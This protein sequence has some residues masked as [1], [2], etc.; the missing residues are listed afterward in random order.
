MDMSLSER[1]RL[2][3]GAIIE[4]Y[5]TF[6]DTIGSRTLVK[7]YNF[8]FSSATIR[9]VMADLE[10]LGYIKKT[11]TS[12]GRVPTDL[13]YKFYLQELL[14]IRKLSKLEKEK[15]ELA[16]EKR[17]LELDAIFEKTSKLLSKM[18]S[19][20]AIVIEPKIEKELIKKIEI[21]Q[22][23]DYTIM[24]IAVLDD[25]SVKTRKIHLDSPITDEETEYI[26]QEIKKELKNSEMTLNQFYEKIKEML[27]NKIFENF[28]EKDD[29]DDGLFIR[30]ESNILK[31]LNNNN[32]VLNMVDIF[33]KK[34]HLRKTFEEIVKKG[35]YEEGKV[36]I[37]LGEDLNIEALSEFSFV[38]STYNLRGSKGVI[39]V[40]GPKRMEYSKTVSLV[41][42]VSE[43]VNR[44][45]QN[46]K[47]EG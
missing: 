2:V 6:G 37:L 28:E 20:A 8:D 47:G 18:S 34:Q 1:E 31:T 22:V 3:L 43:E 16:Y 17:M 15:I 27:S 19:Y 7:K 13:G 21:M 35:N 32:D 5:L 42:Y 10:E 46:L 9:N 12:S 33:N 38:F 39:G 11:H 25:C 41:E 29:E 30:G 26:K 44:V 40:I 14:K 24:T 4:Y 45:I 23:T 36:Y